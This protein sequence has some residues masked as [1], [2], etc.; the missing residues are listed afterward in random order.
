[1]VV[2]EDGE[3]NKSQYRKF[4]IKL[5]PGVNDVLELFEKF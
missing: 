3:V 5:N 2:V 1:M 4:K